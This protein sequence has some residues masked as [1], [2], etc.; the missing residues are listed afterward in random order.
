M[1][2]AG[3]FRSRISQELIAR[4]AAGLRPSATPATQPAPMAMRKEER[5]RQ[6]VTPI[7]TSR[8]PLRA[9]AAMAA[10]TSQ[11]GGRVLADA[12]MAT[13]CHAATS[14]T[15]D[16]TRAAISTNALS[17]RAVSVV[18]RPPVYSADCSMASW[19]PLRLECSR[20]WLQSC[21]ADPRVP[22][23]AQRHPRRPQRAG[24]F[25]VPA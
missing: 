24:R 23:S 8:S 16:P 2:R 10:R 12:I 6:R 22:S 1:T 13:I 19:R 14:T 5:T 15:T 3:V 11:G 25:H 21:T 9:S 20:P 4:S 18:N 17:A 7:L